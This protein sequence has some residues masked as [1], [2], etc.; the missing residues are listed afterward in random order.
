MQEHHEKIAK[1]YV[2]AFYNL[3]PDCLNEQTIGK[4][5]ALGSFL[6]QNQ[7]FLVS[8]SIPSLAL[9]QKQR[10][11]SQIIDIL[12]LDQIFL[13][14]FYILLRDKRTYLLEYICHQFFVLFNKQH[15][16]QY[17]KI[18]TSHTITDQEQ[19]IITNFLKNSLEHHITIK[20]DFIIDKNLISGIKITS[21]TLMWENSIAHQLKNINQAV[22]QQVGL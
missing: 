6:K 8:L 2:S 20:A 3:Y 4:L 19:A 7:R 16:I 1:K 21:E 18:A 22:L 12:K 10:Y 15:H 5:T 9:E 17:F 14:L 13:K 11:V